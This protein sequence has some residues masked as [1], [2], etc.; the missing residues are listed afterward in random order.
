MSMQHILEKTCDGINNYEIDIA[1]LAEINTR[2]RHNLGES[3]LRN[4]TKRYWKHSHILISETY[5]PWKTL[6]KP[7]GATILS[8]QPICNGIISSGQD[9]RELGRWSFTT[10]TGRQNN[11]VTIISAYRIYDVSIKM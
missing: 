4:T 8:L 3:T 7:G 5:I 10:V 6:Y 2:W 9:L 1:Y 11:I